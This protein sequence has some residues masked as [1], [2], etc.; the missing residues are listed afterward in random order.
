MWPPGARLRQ[1]VHQWLLVPPRQQ[2]LLLVRARQGVA[3]VVGAH[4]Q[5]GVDRVGEVGGLGGGTKSSQSFID[6]SIAS[7]NTQGG[8]L[9]HCAHLA[10][11]PT[12]VKHVS[13]ELS[14]DSSQSSKLLILYPVVLFFLTSKND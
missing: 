2:L 1:G 13:T 5:R 6:Q 12:D 11:A 9:A 4:V 3:A 14:I 8:R 10:H 7:T